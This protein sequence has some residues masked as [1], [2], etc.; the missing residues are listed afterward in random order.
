MGQKQRAAH[1]TLRVRRLV[2]GSECAQHCE[3]RPAEE[4]PDRIGEIRGIPQRTARLARTF[5]RSAEKFAT[6]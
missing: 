1:A 4:A 2:L 5:R 6:A 3:H